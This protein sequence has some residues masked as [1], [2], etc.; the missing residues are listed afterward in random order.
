LL[1]PRLKKTFD[2]DGDI[3]WEEKPNV[4]TNQ[5][6]RFSKDFQRILSDTLITCISAGYEKCEIFLGGVVDTVLNDVFCDCIQALGYCPEILVF[7]SVVDDYAVCELFVVDHV[8]H[9]DELS[10]FLQ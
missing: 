2:F 8:C 4:F 9:S 5:R 7:D 6:V 1:E 3:F 10:Y